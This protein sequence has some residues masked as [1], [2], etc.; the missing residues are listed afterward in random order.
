MVRSRVN[1]LDFS[2]KPSRYFLKMENDK[3]KKKF[4][5]KIDLPDS[6]SVTSSKGI[7]DAFRDFYFKLFTEEDIDLDLAD[8]FC[9]DLP[10]LSQLDLLTC[11]GPIRK[12]EIFFAIKHMSN[13]KSP[14]CDGLTKE[15]Y[16]TFFNLIGDH[17]VSLYN[18]IFD[19]GELS[20]SQKL[21]YIS[22]LCKDKNNSSNMKNWR[23]ISLLNIDYKILSK[24][25]TNRLG[26]V[27][28]KLVGI[29]QTCSVK[30]RSIFENCHLLRNIVDYVNQKDLKCSFI[31]LDQEKAF[32]RVNY[33]F[34][35]KVLKAYNFG[36]DFIKWVSILY[37]DVFS[38]VI[39]NGFISDPFSI[40]RGVRQGCSLSPLLYVLVLE[41]FAKKVRDDPDITGIKLPGSA[42]SAKISL[43]ADDST[44]ICCTDSSIQKLFFW[45]DLYG[46]ASGAKLNRLKSKGIWLGKWKSRSDH[47][48]GIS[49]V[50][51]HKIC[52]VLV[53]NNITPDEIW[54][55][56]FK[57]FSRTLD[58]WKMRNLSLTQKSI[59]IKVLACSKIWYVGTIVTM[60]RH[61]LVLFQRTLFR[62]LWNSKS[63]PLA[64]SV[65]YD[66]PTSGGLSIVNIEVKLQAISLKHCQKFVFERSEAKWRFFLLCIGFQCTFEIFIN[67]I[68]IFLI[69]SGVLL[70]ILAFVIYLRNIKRTFQIV[71]L[72]CPQQK[73]F[74]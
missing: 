28:D 50:E 24:V 74:I 63:E 23:P 59:I 66:F 51:K 8:T 31:S 4:I 56:L 26:K 39:V 65:A 60:P 5:E 67:L 46:K 13:N 17:L 58:L 14:G 48:F 9:E 20:D 22:L 19:K 37:N 11:E 43:Y 6:S 15:F 1:F 64:R 45:C 55:P 7:L 3:G 44:G 25:I 18:S 42:N 32:D 62:F 69:A 61:Y 38:S 30:G 49:W 40:T 29:D 68:T 57:K 27:L 34:L 73:S 2:E 54:Q 36:P 35:F 33:K 41:P 71:I 10:K 72:K 47:P 21:S 16:F 52:G 70:F 53:G 12:E